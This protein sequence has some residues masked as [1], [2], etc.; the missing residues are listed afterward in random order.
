V[1]NDELASADANYRLLQNRFG[2]EGNTA[3]MVTNCITMF[4]SAEFRQLLINVV[5]R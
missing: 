2:S 3:M 4:L 5:T 1:L